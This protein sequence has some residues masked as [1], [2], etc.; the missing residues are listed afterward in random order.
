MRTNSGAWVRKAPAIAFLF[1]RLKA[2]SRLT[3]VK[4]LN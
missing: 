2:F 1:S 4:D 3:V